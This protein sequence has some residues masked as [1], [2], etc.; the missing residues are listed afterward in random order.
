MISELKKL[1]TWQNALA[2]FLPLI[3]MPLMG[4]FIVTRQASFTDY[5]QL[6]FQVTSNTPAF[7]FPFI[8][9]AMYA[10]KMNN[11]RKNSY[12]AYVHIRIDLKTYYRA[13]IKVA[14]LVGLLAGFLFVAIPALF[15]L[16]I[17]P[18]TGLISI[19]P[20]SGPAP[21]IE[22]FKSIIELGPLKFTLL[23]SLW[24]GINGAAYSAFAQLIV[25]KV[26][27][28]VLALFGTTIFYLS[29]EL[30]TRLVA[31]LRIYSP[32]HTLFPFGT[33]VSIPNWALLVPLALVIT[34]S[35]II[36]SRILNKP[37]EV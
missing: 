15:T 16:Y 24:I 25:I 12:L 30:L 5:Y 17:A 18:R 20:I 3:L 28:T 8:F 19:N 26:K 4:L 37:V 32:M 1:L 13:K 7:A 21:A 11:E 35:T 29:L 9:T 22:Y 6:F 10:A 2:T 14:A 36:G 33:T 27:H 23:Y 31:P 34:I